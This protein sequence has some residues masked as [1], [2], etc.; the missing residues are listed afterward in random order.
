ML[1][2]SLTIVVSLVVECCNVLVKTRTNIVSLVVLMYCIH[3]FCVW[4]FSYKILDEK[5]VLALF[6]E[7][8]YVSM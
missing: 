7:G 4:C 6:S 8:N 3:V 1:K 2:Y 5:T